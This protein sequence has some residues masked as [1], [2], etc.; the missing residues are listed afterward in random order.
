MM[1][2]IPIIFV[3]TSIPKKYAANIP[4]D[5]DDNS[6]NDNDDYDNDD[7]GIICVNTLDCCSSALTTK[8]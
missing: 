5:N 7:T 6:N 2:M 8:L 1:M 4:I 3:N